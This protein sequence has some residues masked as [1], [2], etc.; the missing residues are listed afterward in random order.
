MH[1]FFRVPALKSTMSFRNLLRAPLALGLA[2]ITIAA[3][4]LKKGRAT[5]AG[6]AQPPG[7]CDE[8]ARIRAEELTRL[9]RHLLTAGEEERLRIAR[10]LHDGL[11]STLT[12]VNLDLFWIQQRLADQPALANRLARA[13]EVLASTV[14]MKRRIIHDLRPTV[15]DTLGLS[16]AIES[17]AADFSQ[18]N[19]VPV[20]TE[21]PDELPALKDGAPIALFRICEEAL[22]NAARHAQATSIRISLREEPAG[23]ALEVLDD[24]IGIDL[25]AS[26]GVPA[27]IGLLSMRERAAAIGGTLSVERG[28]DGRGTVVR[29]ILP[30]ADAKISTTSVN[31]PEPSRR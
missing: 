5:D 10:D 27:S 28:A 9:S 7:C 20:A 14:E 8:G 26:G 4:C 12:A 18:R 16:A 2:L 22:T 15:L 25:T 24:G 1:R 31:A 21:L 11:G 6:P 13:K 17:H 3:S 23:I 30:R 29:V 19:A